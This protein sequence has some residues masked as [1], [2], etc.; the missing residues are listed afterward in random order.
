MAIFKFGPCISCIIINQSTTGN[1]S[2][3]QFISVILLICAPIQGVYRWYDRHIHFVMCYFCAK[4]VFSMLHIFMETK[5]VFT[6][7]S[8]LFALFGRVVINIITVNPFSVPL[9]FGEN[10]PSAK[11]IPANFFR[12][13]RW[14]KC[15][16]WSCEY[17]R[18]L[19]AKY[20]NGLI[21][22]SGVTDSRIPK[23]KNLVHSKKFP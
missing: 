19:S 6:S 21:K 5:R 4:N 1:T 17:P 9:F 22:G 12:Q 11:L 20:E 15:E 8:T 14:H 23:V 7:R 16:N 3:C 18:E 13:C 2:L 10:S